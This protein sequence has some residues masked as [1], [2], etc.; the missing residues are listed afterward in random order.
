MPDTPRVSSAMADIRSFF[1]KPR[2]SEP[3]RPLRDPRSIVTWNANGLAP[4]IAHEPL[5][6]RVRMA[7]RMVERR[8]GGGEP[9]Q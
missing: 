9:V 2:L 5:G 4:R 8:Q 1:K 6:V 7:R 3:A